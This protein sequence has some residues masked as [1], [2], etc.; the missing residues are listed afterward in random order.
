MDKM[1][2]QCVYGTITATV[3]L[4]MLCRAVYIYFNPDEFHDQPMKK[5][6]DWRFFFMQIGF[7]NRAMLFW[8]LMWIVIFWPSQF[9]GKPGQCKAYVREVMVRW[10]LGYGFFLVFYYSFA[11]LSGTKEEDFDPSGHIACGLLAQTN[12]FS[13]YEFL[14]KQ[15]SSNRKSVRKEKQ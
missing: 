2:V 5:R 14:Y 4:A 3:C 13:I 10:L 15:H 8:S 11:I 12:H 7:I 9:G 1:R 6:L